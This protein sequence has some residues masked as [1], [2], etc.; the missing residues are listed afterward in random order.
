MPAAF[1]SEADIIASNNWT[2]E[3]IDAFEDLPV[4]SVAAVNG[5]ALGGGLEVA[6]SA[7]YRVMS[8]AA[9]VG[10][11]EVN[12]GLFPG[13]GGTVRLPRAA[14][15]EVAIDWISS[16]KPRK[17]AAALEACVVDETSPPESLRAAALRLLREAADGKLDWRG[18]QER[19]RRPLPLSTE[20][21]RSIFEP[22]KARLA[23]SGPKHQPAALVAVELMQQAALM[24]RAGA[25]E[26]EALHFARV[27]KTQAA[28]SL[29]QVFHNDQ[30]LKKLFRGH[31]RHAR[32]VK[33]AAVLGAGIRV[34]AS[35]LPARCTAS[36][37]G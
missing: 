30:T 29:V 33:Q 15:A 17:A 22:A 26:L 21:L 35:R 23:A 13:A 20:Q 31:S 4:P 6:L 24:D 5:Y 11:P 9:Q 32:P 7:T 18:R 19:K 36:R 37:C 3:P 34:G 8:T 12:L 25:R 16:G 28:N 1:M 10:V 2:N 14:S 27:A